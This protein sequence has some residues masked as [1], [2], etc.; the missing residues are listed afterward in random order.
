MGLKSFLFGSDGDYIDPPDYD[1]E[2]ES[3]YRMRDF[4]EQFVED[5]VKL[6]AELDTQLADTVQNVLGYSFDAMEDIYQGGQELVDDFKQNWKPIQ[7]EYLAQV[8]AMQM[9]GEHDRKA[10][11]AGQDMAQAYDA[12]HAQYKRQLQSQGIDPSQDSGAMANSLSMLM[13]KNASIAGTQTAE[14]DRQKLMGLDLA[15]K[16]T[17]MGQDINQ[18]GFQNQ[19][20]ATDIGNAAA[21][22]DMNAANTRAYLANTRLDPLAATQGV[23]M[24]IA[25]LRNTEYQQ[26]MQSKGFENQTADGGLAGW[27]MNVAS[28]VAGNYIGNKT[29]GWGAA[30]G[31]HVEAPGGMKS[32]SGLLR[33]SDG[34]Y[35]LPAEV[36]NNLGAN[37]LDKF[38]EKNTGV[39]PSKKQALPVGDM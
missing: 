22:T 10:A 26:K 28:N 2:F 33:I 37:M 6:I 7:D 5:Q 4:A 21:A 30:E 11:Q 36:V 19:A 9:Q 20:L 8:N 25:N 39:K 24:D 27:G 14:R 18:R 29:A 12:A 31:G 13:E 3:M 34:E 35:V 16:A 17:A 1:F 32:D 15:G 38:V 23:N